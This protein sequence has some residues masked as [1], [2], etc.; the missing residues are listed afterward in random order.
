MVSGVVTALQAEYDER[1]TQLETLEAEWAGKAYSEEAKTRCNEL[2]ESIEEF[3]VKIELRS[4]QAGFNASAFIAGRECVGEASRKAAAI[5]AGIE[6]LDRD[7]LAAQSDVTAQPEW[8][9][10]RGG[11]GFGAALQPGRERARVVGSDLRG[12]GKL[13]AG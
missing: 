9:G 2:N 4:I 5:K 6:P 11:R 12:A 10:R 3:R 1:V 8:A 13:Q 7:F